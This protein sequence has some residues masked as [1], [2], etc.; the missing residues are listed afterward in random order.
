MAL[1]EKRGKKEKRKKREKRKEKKRN[2]EEKKWCLLASA[3]QRESME[4]GVCQLEHKD[5]TCR[6]EKKRRNKTQMAFGCFTKAE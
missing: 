1:G 5:G 3:R 2:T 4:D 6:K